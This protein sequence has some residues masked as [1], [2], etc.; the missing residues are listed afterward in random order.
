[1]THELKRWCLSQLKDIDVHLPVGTQYYKL[2][3]SPSVEPSIDAGV[4]SLPLLPLVSGDSNTSLATYVNI[5]PSTSD[6]SERRL[7]QEQLDSRMHFEVKVD[8]SLGMEIIQH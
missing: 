7:E 2:L 6:H 5:P 3:P 8:R 4:E 1:M